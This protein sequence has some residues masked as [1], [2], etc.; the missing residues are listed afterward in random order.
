MRTALIAALGLLAAGATA[1]ASAPRAF[2]FS[3]V[4]R[5]PA[6]GEMGVAVQSHWFS[7]GSP[8]AKACQGSSRLSLRKNSE[9]LSALAVPA[10]LSR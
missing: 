9:A 1:W 3:I 6:T 2:T 8:S 7:V 10:F 5:D 4:A